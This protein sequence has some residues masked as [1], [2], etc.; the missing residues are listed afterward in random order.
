MWSSGILRDQK[1]MTF[2]TVYYVDAAA[3]GEVFCYDIGTFDSTRVITPATANLALPAGVATQV[4]AATT[5]GK[6]QTWGY[7]DTVGVDG[8]TDVTAGAPLTTVNAIKT[9]VIATA[10][11]NGAGQYVPAFASGVA[12]TTNA[13]AAKAVMVR[14]Y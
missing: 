8:T 12:Y 13:V 1:D 7:N 9:L 6:M 5:Y 4:Q 10:V 11:T 14:C 2:R 3:V